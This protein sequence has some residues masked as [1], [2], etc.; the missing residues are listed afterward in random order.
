MYEEKEHL[1]DNEEDEDRN[2]DDIS[3]KNNATSIEFI[4]WNTHNR[5]IVLQSK[6]VQTVEDIRIQKL[7]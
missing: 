4:N 5:E 7:E 3:Q 2:D 1:S 6:S